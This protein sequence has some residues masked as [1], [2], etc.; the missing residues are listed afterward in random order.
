MLRRRQPDPTASREPT[1]DAAIDWRL[2]GQIAQTHG[3]TFA[4]ASRV[5]PYDR[6]RAV[7]ATY[8][9]CRI[10]D[11]IADRS[12]DPVLAA[13]ALDDWERQLDEP[14]HPVAVAFA[15][16]RRQYGVSTNAARD[17]LTGVR[18]DLAPRRYATWDDLRRYCYHVAGTVGLMVAP[19]L[20][21][22]DDGALPRAVDLGIAM[23][24]TN[25]LRDVAEDAGRGR[26][27]LP[28][29]DLAAFGCDPEAIVRG[30]PNGEFAA[31]LAFEIARARR[32]YAAAQRGIPALSPAGQLTALAASRLYAAILNA[33]EAMDYDVF[34]GRAYLPLSRKLGAMPGVTAAF[35]RLSWASSPRGN[36]P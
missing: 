1:D 2:C 17:L 19:I 30:Q 10:A 25:I 35:V 6:R 23:Q 4:F 8:A 9:F 13:R 20:G 7:H 26:L 31:L 24:L 27:Y 32:L 12:S 18:M 3:R 36:E 29:D 16:T 33:I 14:V 34:G 28:L 11:D 22:R 21:C 15:A 5:L